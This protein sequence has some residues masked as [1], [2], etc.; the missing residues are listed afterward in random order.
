MNP[1]TLC[2]SILL[3]L[4]REYSGLL[5]LI[6]LF[7]NSFNVLLVCHFCHTYCDGEDYYSFAT[8]NAVDK[9]VNT[10]RCLYL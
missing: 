6:N 4:I 3:L 9:Q 5:Y 10:S 2:V 1:C 7:A 8:V